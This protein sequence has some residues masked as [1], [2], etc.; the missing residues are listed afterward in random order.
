MLDGYKIGLLLIVN[1]VEL[2]QKLKGKIR[3]FFCVSFVNYCRF[4]TKQKGKIR[5]FFLG[6][7]FVDFCRFKTKLKDKVRV[8]FGAEFVDYCQF[9]R[10]RRNKIR[11]FFGGNFVSFCPSSQSRRLLAKFDLSRFL[12]ENL[13]QNKG[14]SQVARF[15][16]DDVSFGKFANDCA[17]Q[18]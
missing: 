5:S 1:V 4:K 2:S 16:R 10:E 17:G 13:Q 9:K 6:A 12:H 18:R 3:S 7:D 14:L 15:C 8:F 11:S